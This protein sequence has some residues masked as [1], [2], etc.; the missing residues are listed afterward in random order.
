MKQ[1]GNQ[2]LDLIEIIALNYCKT[3]WQKIWKSQLYKHI[4]PSL[5]YH[6]FSWSDIALI[7][8]KKDFAMIMTR[9]LKCVL[10]LFKPD[11][12]SPL[13]SWVHTDR[14]HL[15][16]WQLWQYLRGKFFS[17]NKRSHFIE[18]CSEIDEW[19]FF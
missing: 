9:F 4:T 1:W 5:M 18:K 8:L 3:D 15:S 12:S 6:T 7:S 11:Y 16:F 19:H 2:N 10:F 14:P 13:C 17:T